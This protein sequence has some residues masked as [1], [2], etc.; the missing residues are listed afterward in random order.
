MYYHSLI[1]GKNGAITGELE[2]LD[3]EPWTEIVEATDGTVARM[4][5]LAL[6]NTGY[7]GVRWGFQHKRCQCEGRF[8]SYNVVTHLFY[9]S[10]DWLR[11]DDRPWP[12]R[13]VPGPRR[14]PI[15]PAGR[16]RP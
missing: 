5:A 11:T 7:G 2:V 10:S 14:Q 1:T 6:L 12:G 4:A 15:T 9:P 16:R 8:G 13:T 3:P